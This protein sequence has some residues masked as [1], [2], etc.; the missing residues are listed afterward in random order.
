[1][2]ELVDVDYRDPWDPRDE[3]PDPPPSRAEYEHDSVA[4]A[5][6][7]RPR[8]R[9]ELEQLLAFGSGVEQVLARQELERR[10]GAGYQASLLGP[11]E[12]LAETA[13]RPG[14]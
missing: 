12:R 14:A 1:M 11:A 10:A 3:R 5:A 4:P 6:R 13:P 2:S 7:E 9:D 8:R